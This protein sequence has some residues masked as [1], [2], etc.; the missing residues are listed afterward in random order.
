MRS[1]DFTIPGEPVGKGRPRAF[2]MKGAGIRMYTPKKTV[3]YENLVK[4]GMQL[5]RRRDRGSS[6]V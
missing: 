6:A 5:S 3:N 4:I 2:V 1:I